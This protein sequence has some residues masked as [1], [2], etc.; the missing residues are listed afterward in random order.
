ME[1]YLRNVYSFHISITDYQSILSC[2]HS[3]IE[4]I[5]SIKAAFGK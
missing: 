2:H 4:S 1:E 5:S 3:F